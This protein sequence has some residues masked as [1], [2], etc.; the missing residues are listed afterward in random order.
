MLIAWFVATCCCGS[1]SLGLVGEKAAMLCQFLIIFVILFYVQYSG[2][3]SAW[4]SGRPV[5]LSCQLMC[6]IAFFNILFGFCLCC[7]TCCFGTM[8]IAAV[9]I[10][11]PGD[12]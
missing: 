8:T 6:W 5:L 1:A 2:L 4:W 12:Q 7:M 10:K 11:E 9:F 3:L